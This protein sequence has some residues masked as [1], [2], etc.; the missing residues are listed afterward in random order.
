MGFP[1]TKPN[2]V[3]NRTCG[4]RLRVHQS[5]P[6]RGRLARRWAPMAKIYA[7]LAEDAQQGWI[8]SGYAALPSRSVV[9]ITNVGTRHTV[10]CEILQI[11]QNFIRRYNK[12]A[13]YKIAAPA[14][15]VVMSAWYRQRLGYSTQETIS[16]MTTQP[17]NGVW[18]R[19]RACTDHPQVVVRVAAWL[20]FISVCLGM[21]GVILGALSLRAGA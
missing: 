4:E 21:V 10:Y 11:D 8:W 1:R 15:A 6:A 3:L 16:A 2:Y 5:H 17:A 7:S 14:D 13:T 12:A 20:G 18:G 9:K 19:F